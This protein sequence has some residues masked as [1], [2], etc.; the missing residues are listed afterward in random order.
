MK[1][2]ALPC[3]NHSICSSLKVWLTRTS[4]GSEPWLTPPGVTRRVS[5]TP[6]ASPACG[7]VAASPRMSSPACAACGAMAASS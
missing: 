5:G 6:G 1:L 7:A 3:L 2:S 4:K